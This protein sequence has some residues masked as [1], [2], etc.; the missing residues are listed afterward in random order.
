MKKYRLINPIKEAFRIQGKRWCVVTLTTLAL[1]LG[2]SIVACGLGM[3]VEGITAAVVAVGFT[4][5][6]FYWFGVKTVTD[7]EEE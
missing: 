2:L 4:L 5:F 1:L 6:L 3:V 7:E